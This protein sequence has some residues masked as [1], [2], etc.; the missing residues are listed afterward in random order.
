VATVE[1]HH[2]HWSSSRSRSRGNVKVSLFSS[3][4]SAV[5]GTETSRSSTRRYGY[6]F[7]SGNNSPA[8]PLVNVKV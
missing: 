3:I 1:P 2:Y 8:V 7:R 6:C 5:V 4:V